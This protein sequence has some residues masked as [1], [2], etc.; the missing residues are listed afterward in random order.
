MCLYE[1]GIAAI[2]P[3]SESQDLKGSVLNELRDR[4]K[5][6]YVFFDN[7][8]IGR[9]QSEKFSSINKLPSFEI[10]RRYSCKDISDF[11]KKYGID[12]AWELLSIHLNY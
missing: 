5:Y 7:D 10:P 1:M 9:I 12:Q 4:F 3:Q 2:A 8:D 6:I 11:I